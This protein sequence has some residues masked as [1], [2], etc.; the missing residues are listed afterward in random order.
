M[1]LSDSGVVE[2]GHARPPGCV[3]P[4]PS[5]S[6]AARRPGPRPPPPP[7]AARPSPLPAARAAPKLP[8]AS[9]RAPSSRHPT[10]MRLTKPK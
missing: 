2:L 1:E 9:S 4:A 10:G 6:P 3:V 7:G 5:A 8:V